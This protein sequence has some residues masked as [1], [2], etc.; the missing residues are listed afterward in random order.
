MQETLGEGSFGI[1]HRVKAH[2][3]APFAL[4]R[5]RKC[6]LNLAA[7]V[8]AS[9]TGV[10]SDGKVCVPTT[11]IELLDTKTY[12]GDPDWILQKPQWMLKMDLVSAFTW[13]SRDIYAA[14]S[15]ITLPRLLRARG[16]SMVDLS[17]PNMGQCRDGRNVLIDPDAITVAGDDPAIGV[18]APW[19]W[20]EWPAGYTKH[21]GVSETLRRAE[22]QTMLTRWA[23]MH[24]AF[25]FAADRELN[26][27][28]HL[29]NW[30]Y[31]TELG[32]KLADK[33]RDK[34]LFAAAAAVEMELAAINTT[35]KLVDWTPLNNICP[36]FLPSK[37]V[38]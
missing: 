6:R 35:W 9:A 17:P 31:R 21:A 3:R 16:L 24:T 2:G 22:V 23:G 36:R 37:Y 12:I 34:R 18:S 8:R 30:K 27:N 14:A 4:K 13:K 25:A 38:K 28:Q 20:H 19:L 7:F 29:Y 33:F 1:V 10:Y 11:C 15:A 32:A 5:F 26:E